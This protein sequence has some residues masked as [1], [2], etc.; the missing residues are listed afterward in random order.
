[1]SAAPLAAVVVP[2]YNAGPYLSACLRSLAAQTHPDWR[3]YLVDDGS[4]DGS[5]ALCDQAARE[6]ARFTVLHQAQCGVSAARAAGVARRQGR[7]RGLIAFCDADDICHPDLL[8]VLTGAAQAAAMPVGLLPVRQLYRRSAA[9]RP[10]PPGGRARAGR[11]APSG[12][13]A[14]RPRGGFQLCNK[15]YRADVLEPAD[16][17]NGFFL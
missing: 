17:D 7:R 11:A 2:V 9:R 14:A 6:D 5:G 8:R 16:F 15:L 3:C 12:S 1:M 4:D 10:R 13:A